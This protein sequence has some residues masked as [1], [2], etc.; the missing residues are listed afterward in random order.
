[1]KKILVALD[2]SKRSGDVLATALTLAREHEGQVTLL[3]A[4]TVPPDLP[5]EAFSVT[6]D[7]L[8]DV[9]RRHA[10]EDLQVVATAI[11]K[12]LVAGFDVV[13]GSPW[14]SICEEAKRLDVDLVVLGSHGYGALDRLL[15]TTAAKVVNHCDRSVLVVRDPA[16]PG[17]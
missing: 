8:V 9:L 15:G 11:P 1:M 10:L 14:Q 17:R 4:V 16:S 5:S 2:T 3:R 6:P 7:G 13:V 12:E